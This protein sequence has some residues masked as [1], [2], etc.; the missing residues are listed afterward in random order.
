MS[1]RFSVHAARTPADFAAARNL[2][3]EVY[4]TRLGLN[5]QRWSLEDARDRAGY[6]FL[7]REHAVLVGSGRA[8][9]TDSPLC[10]IRE[11]GQ[12]PANLEAA[13]DACEVSRIAT[14]RDADG[15]PAS[16][17]LLGMGAK[18]LLQHTDLRR[19][20][21][22]AKVSVLWLY[23]KIGAVDLGT[24]F[25]IPERGDF[26]YGVI[27][28]ELGEAAAAVDQFGQFGAAV[29]DRTSSEAR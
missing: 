3:N 27:L 15:I 19:Y 26:E 11:L 23:Q 21:A 24:R 10:E 28:G 13:T 17:I 2:R 29:T 1:G 14:R 6:V 5:T 20:V 12:L 9:R 8:V 18:W 25:W 16:L 4:W 22:Y 7:L